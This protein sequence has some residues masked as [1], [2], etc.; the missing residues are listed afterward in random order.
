MQNSAVFRSAKIA[1]AFVGLVVGA[2]FATGAE[3]IQY[4]VGFGEIGIW[5]AILAG[6][7]VAVGGAVILQLGSAFLA[8]EHKAVFRSVT[9]PVIARILDVSVSITLF[10]IG[11]VMLAGAG[12]TMHQQLG[13]PTW[14]GAAIMTA[15]VIVTGLLDVEKV[16]SIISGLTPFVVVAVVGAFLATVLTLDGSFTTNEAMAAQT[17]TPINPWWLSA[18]NY[19]GLVLVMAVSMC[20]VIG[21][22][23][24]NP[25]EAFFGGLA[26]GLLYTVLMV[27]AGVLLY[28][29]FDR[30]G[31]ASV[32]MLE[33]FGAFHP[34]LGWAMLA[35]IYAMIYNSAIGMFYALG[36]RISADRPDRYRPA[37]IAVTLV[38][39]AVSFLGFGTLMNVV[40]PLLGY[41]GL[42]LTVVLVAWWLTHRGE[43]S[44][45]RTLRMRLSSL[46]RLQRHPEKRFT[47]A[48]ADALEEAA[49][50]SVAEPAAVTGAIERQVARDLDA[51]LE[52]DP[53]RAEGSHR[54]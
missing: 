40:Y 42:L 45:E 19:T 10:A 30:I 15:L 13:W 48:H 34:V 38:G 8:N 49:A 1:L 37:F 53:G 17:A 51:E 21:G 47:T 36:R 35:V 9:H 16:S 41:L 28:L 24:T 14:A 6:V 43:L 11:F 2:G 18:L 39:F 54:A 31:H 3:V 27:M 44:A 32:P 4:F 12:A 5:G 46:I 33:L 23:I 20:L 26:G 52:D 50:H 25:R 7:L 29:N 22:S